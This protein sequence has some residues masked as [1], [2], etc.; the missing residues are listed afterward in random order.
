[1]SRKW[2]RVA[3]LLGTVFCAVI[4]PSCGSNQKLVSI[5]LQPSGGF[6][7]EGFGATGQFT[8]IGTYIHPPVSKD[9]TKE[10][11]WSLDIENFATLT[12]TGLITYTRADGCGSGNVTATHHSDPG[13]SDD[14]V[15]VGTAPVKGGKDGTQGCL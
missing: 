5:T 1:M 2:L 9:I 10:V 6:V 3:C 14:A 8:A 4:L 13:H 12:Q 7:F 15:L 11:V